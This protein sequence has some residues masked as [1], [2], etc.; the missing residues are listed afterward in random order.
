MIPSRLEAHETA[1]GMGQ[2]IPRAE[3]CK[4]GSHG[5]VLVQ[6]T[7][8]WDILAAV[9]MRRHQGAHSGHLGS[10]EPVLLWAHETNQRGRRKG[11]DS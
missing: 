7:C 11:G 10:P 8:G 1:P 2:F 9:V 3:T 4:Q 5:A 6:N